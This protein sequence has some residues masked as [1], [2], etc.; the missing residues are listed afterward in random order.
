MSRIRKYIKDHSNNDALSQAENSTP[1][2]LAISR[3][4][5]TVVEVLLNEGANIEHKSDGR[6]TPLISACS[7]GFLEAVKLLIEHGADINIQT[8]TGVT[9][10]FLAAKKQH[11]SVVS[12]LLE[13]KDWVVNETDETDGCTLLHHVVCS[14]DPEL[15][16]NLIRKGANIDAKN[17]SGETPV[18]LATKHNCAD[19]LK[20]LMEAGASFN[21]SAQE[22]DIALHEAI[23]KNNIE[24]T[25]LLLNNGVD[26]DQTSSDKGFTPL[27]RACFNGRV[28]VIKLLIEGGADLEATTSDGLTCL[29]VAAINKHTE[30]VHY[31]VE[32]DNCPINATTQ[33]GYSALHHIVL[34]DDLDTTSLLIKKEADLDV[35]T[36]DGETPVFLATKH[37]CVGSL[38]AR[39]DF[40]ANP[41]IK[42]KVKQ[43][44]QFAI[45]EAMNDGHF[46]A[47]M[48]LLNHGADCTS[49]RKTGKSPLDFA[50]SV[51]MMKLIDSRLETFAQKISQSSG[52]NALE[53]ADN[54][55]SI[56][57]ST[58]DLIASALGR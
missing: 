7:I 17:Q 54:V 37:N 49:I 10:L 9:C 32:Q 45:N 22:A 18:F 3:K 15:T 26:S 58:L 19:S 23:V 29:L 8:P 28:E 30:V 39:L 44:G 46:E 11:T 52:D 42:T 1:L 31:L 41:D 27:M 35:E 25:K 36:Q 6:H 12:Y 57:S 56:I 16:T 53:A 24:M 50:L 47:V 48:T 14:N 20:A 21:L 13:I 55:S 40:G 51:A 43:N 5:A 2:E 38:K 34:W 33:N 4:D